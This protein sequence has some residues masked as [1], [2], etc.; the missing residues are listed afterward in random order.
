MNNYESL[1][2]WCQKRNDETHQDWKI[3][4][5]LAK[6]DRE[7]E[8]V[9]FPITWSKM[10]EI[11][12]EN[13]ST[14]HFRKYATGVYDYY[15]YINNQ[16]GVATRILSIS[17]IHFPFCKPLSTFEEYV[18][19]VDIL[20]LNGDILDCTQLSKF[21][22]MYRTNPLQEMI[23]ARQYL[24]DLI[25]MIKPKKVLVTYGNHDLRLASYVAKNIDNEL[26]ELFPMTALDYIFVDGFVWYNR[27]NGERIKYEAL[28]DVFKDSG[29][30]IDYTGKWYC[31]IGQTI[32]CHPKAFSSAILKTAERAMT[33]FRNEGVPFTS[34]VMAHTHRQGSYMIG[35]TTLYEQGA[36][37]ETDKMMYGDG[38][39]V[40]SQKQG[41]MYICQDEDGSIIPSKTKIVTL[42]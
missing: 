23:G 20:Q 13:V 7:S 1:L 37:C 22:K 18:G 11:L 6:K 15:K 2:D 14:D 24:I 10:I 38:Q 35:N 16:N 33:F 32:F 9:K 27:Q 3:R 4:L 28:Q 25:Y 41:F 29:I 12:G 5:V 36:A 19:V 17:D 34:I 31:Q 30:D 8:G 26:S 39:L 21:P 42:N 40:N